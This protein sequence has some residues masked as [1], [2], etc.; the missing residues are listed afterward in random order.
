M[1]IAFSILSCSLGGGRHRA[2]VRQSST[3]AVQPHG[4]PGYC[5]SLPG[6][7]GA[8]P[9]VTVNVN[10]RLL[11]P[12]N[13]SL[14]R[15]LQTGGSFGVVYKG[16]EVATGETVAIKHVSRAAS[17]LSRPETLGVATD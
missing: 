17:A 16:I 3:S 10:A 4:Q 6:A 8:W 12:N 13:V 15:G 11:V 7:G 5:Q 9:Y 14:T 1:S 2:A